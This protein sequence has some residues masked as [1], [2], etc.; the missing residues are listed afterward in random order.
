[1]LYSEWS[2]K[3]AVIGGEWRWIEVA[4]ASLW[5]TLYMSHPHILQL[6][7]FRWVSLSPLS[8]RQTTKIQLQLSKR[9]RRTRSDSQSGKRMQLPLLLIMSGEIERERENRWQVVGFSGASISFSQSAWGRQVSG[10]IRSHLQLS[11]HHKQ[12][13]SKSHLL[14]CHGLADNA[15]LLLCL[16]CQ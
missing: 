11:T 8:S 13:H 9:N 1:M 10:V 12:Q 7:H 3:S 6:V 16:D 15:T 14:I 5:N 4:T 2:S